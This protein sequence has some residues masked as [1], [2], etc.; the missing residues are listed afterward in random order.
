MTLNELFDRISNL[1]AAVIGDH[2]LVGA[3]SVVTGGS[4]FPQ[5]SLILGAPAKLVRPLTPEQIEGMASSA[6]QYVDKAARYRSGLR[7][8]D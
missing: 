3:G 1:R 8:I 6:A 7:R 2:C 5:D 4:R